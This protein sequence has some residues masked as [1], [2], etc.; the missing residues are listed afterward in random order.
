MKK[1]LL[2]VIGLFLVISLFVFFLLMGVNRSVLQ[3]SYYEQLISETALVDEVY[4]FARHELP[5]MALED[6]ADEEDE[7]APDF[8]EEKI[9]DILGIMLDVYDEDWFESEFL[10]ASE[11][12]TDVLGGRDDSLVITI[13]LTERRDVLR[14]EL[15]A[16]FEDIDAEE[17]AEME[18][19]DDE[20]EKFVDEFLAEFEFVNEP[21]EVDLSEEEELVQVVENFNWYRQLIFIAFGLFFF[22]L[23]LSSYFILKWHML[24]F[25]G[26]ISLVMGLL[27]TGMVMILKGI[28]GGFYGEVSEL[29]NEVISRNVYEQIINI[30]LNPFICV[31]VIVAAL[32]LVMTVVSIVFFSNKKEQPE[33]YQEDEKSKLE[34][35]NPQKE[36]KKGDE[37]TSKEE[38]TEED[39]K[40]ED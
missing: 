11:Q 32:G 37:E 8:M 23:L 9:G 20:I 10:A 34:T 5:E 3:Q 26:I 27:F 30:T 7:E 1:F 18:I 13:D 16:F 40:I 35:I 22:I 19:S 38:T 4:E 2:V 29:T 36:E 6:M 39:T 33:L 25:I 14:D 31:P 17:R 24:K 21:L 28:L 15:I 12:L